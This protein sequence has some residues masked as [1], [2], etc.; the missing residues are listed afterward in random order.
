MSLRTVAIL[1]GIGF[2]LRGSLAVYAGLQLRK[3]GAPVAG[4]APAG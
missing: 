2:I 4:M 3:V 1:A